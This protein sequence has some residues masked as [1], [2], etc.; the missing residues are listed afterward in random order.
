[1]VQHF[2]VIYTS[3]ITNM[4][5]KIK[6]KSYTPGC[7]VLPENVTVTQPVNDKKIVTIHYLCDFKQIVYK[8]DKSTELLK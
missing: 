5:L 6:N 8:K 1:M 4:S 3:V 7:I 2:D